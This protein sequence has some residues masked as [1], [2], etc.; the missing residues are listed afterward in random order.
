MKNLKKMLAALLVVAM[1]A[2]IAVVPAFAESFSYESQATA[3]NKLGLY[4]GVSTEPGVF[5]PDLGT[6]LDRQTGVVMLL[7]MFGQEEE[8]K[9]LTDAQVNEKLAKFTDG[10]TVAEWAKRQ[11]AYAVDKGFVKGYAEDSTFRPAAGLNGKAYSSLLLQQLG[12]DGDFDYH[13]A[14]TKL[15]EIG[16]LTAAEATLFNS[17][18][19]IKK[20]SLVGIS[21]GALQAK[22]KADGVKLVKALLKSENIT[23]EQLKDAGVKYLDIVSV[24]AIADVDV[25]INGT[26]ELP[27]TVK[28]TYDDESTGDVN[29]TWPTVNTAAEGEQTIEGVIADTTVKATVK[30]I[31]AP[32]V[33]KVDGASAGNLKEVVL[34]FNKV[35]DEDKATNKANYKVARNSVANAELSADKKTVTLL[36][37]T[38][39]GQQADV[40]VTVDKDLGFTDDVE[41]TVKNIKDTAAPTIVEVVAVGNGLVKVTYNE[42]V[43]FATGISNYTIDGKLFGSKQPELSANGKTVSF[44]LTTRLAAGT[45]KMVVKNKV[46]DFADFAI[47]ANETEFAVVE[48][49]TAATGTVKEATQTK[50]VIE[51]NEEVVAPA[52]A[53]VSTNTSATIVEVK[54][55]EDNKTLTITFDIEDALPTAGGKVTIDDLTD[56]SGNKVDFEISVSPAYD[57]ERPE[58]VGYEIKEN[59]TQIVLEFNE[60]VLEGGKFELKNADGDVVSVVTPAT[61][62]RDGGEDVKTKLVLAKSGS[63]TFA[64][65]KHTLKMSE[66][67]DNNPLKNEILTQTVTIEI[68]DQVAPEVSSI[69]RKG[70]GETDEFVAPIRNEIYVTYSED[71]DVNT[72]T[73]LTSYSYIINNKVYALDKDL[74]DVDL[75][76]DGQTVC[77]AFATD[78]GDDS[79]D[80]DSIDYLQIDSVT[81]LAGN[82]IVTESYDLGSYV[83]PTAPEITGAV[84]TG[85]NKIEL[86]LGEGDSVNSKTIDPAD[87]VIKA[88][89]GSAAIDIDAWDA[90]YKDDKI[91][92][93]VNAD[94][95]SDGKYEGKTLYLSLVDEVNTVNAFE[96]PLEI[97]AGFADGEVEDGFAPKA[98]SVASA[99]YD[100]E[101][102]TVVTIE[103]TEN[104][105]FDNG[106]E[107]LGTDLAQFRVKADGSTKVA[108]I[109]YYDAVADNTATSNVDEEAAAKLVV[110]IDGDY[111]GKK[112]QVIFLANPE[113]TIVD[114]SENALADFDLSK[115]VD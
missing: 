50:V 93:T 32:A 74:V 69:Y 109:F 27:A 82:E 34:N 43:D 104:L 39:V 100:D 78:E 13:T 88:G 96:Q 35:L 102:G 56:Y 25:D 106:E 92:L 73:A 85:T 86:T 22:Y 80:V 99:V 38:K 101:E 8:A 72:A 41:V 64:S 79:V 36:L 61:Y 24:A 7:R 40:T 107:L 46:K 68:D 57:T 87:F 89:T 70:D 111:S 112:V 6:A 97:D 84:V 90:E 55:A 67:A 31:V 1:I 49:T 83:A 29:V 75:L 60:E 12:Y 14:A 20:D 9:L 23:V 4:L 66:V 103:L 53:D 51:F 48:D 3:L 108:Q 18:A 44:K 110:V 10:G 65:E 52:K 30:V 47:E 71:V 28:A 16:G 98:D 42:P 63:G 17:D 81:D 5:D 45:H 33:L 94:L 54:L 58:F 2:S 114:E 105:A 15:S 11:V 19:Q 62:Y 21:F 91:I 113:P 76:S 59:Q 95:T 77:L 26:P 115:T 37:G